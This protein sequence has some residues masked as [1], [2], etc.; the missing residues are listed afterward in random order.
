MKNFLRGLR[1]TWPYRGRLWASIVCAFFAA[2]LWSL[3]LSAVYPVLVLLQ[4]HKDQ[5]TWAQILDGHIK[6]LQKDEADQR[7]NLEWA[8]ARLRAAEQANPGNKKDTEERVLSGKIASIQ[9]KLDGLSWKIYWHQVAKEFVVR[10]LPPERFAALAAFFGIMLGAVALRGV[11]E[12]LQ[13]SLV[14]SVTNRVIC[15]LR[16]RVF[17]NVIHLDVGHFN[18]QGSHGT[19]ANL[20]N[21]TEAF[22]VGVRMLYGRVIGE[23]LKALACVIAACLLAWQ[24]TLLFLVLVPV[25]AYVLA[26]VGRMMK[27]AS[28]RLLERMSD[29]Y[30]IAGEA[31]RAIRVV[32]AFTAEA[33]ERKRFDAAA[34]A[35]AAKAVRVINLDAATSPV[36]ELLGVGAISV[37]LLAGAYLVLEGK[38]DLFGFRLCDYPLDS[39]TLLQIYALLAAIADPVRKLSSVFTKL[40]SGA[41]AADRVFAAL[42]QRPKVLANSLGPVLSRHA[43]SIQFRDVCFS[44]EPGRSTLSNI[45]LDIRFGETVALVGKNGCGKSTLV[46]LL[47]RFY[48]P[49]YGA[50]LVDGVELRHAHLRSLRRQVGLVTQETVLFDDTVFSNIAYGCRRA[51]REQ[52]EEVSRRAYAHDFIEKMSAGYDTRIGDAGAKLSGGQ[53]QR[54]ALARAMLRDP[55]ILILDEF[56]SQCDAESEALIHQALRRFV[57]NRTT[58]IISHR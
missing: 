33:Q 19:M 55:A 40:Q 13:E 15:D 58:F 11:F 54:I 30:R 23:P 44:Y 2:V 43:E 42:D 14:G 50:V 21:D 35:Y 57:K 5:K 24:L 49:D 48:D 28:R 10:C 46:G 51:T 36:I 39:P 17:R 7:T 20:T 37:A 9:S 26:K 31:F 27:R 32:K 12:Y 4:D 29:L 25:S 47:P 3:N 1:A 53:R 8:Q 16:N 41:A 18:D 45:R 52:V 56:T 34:K 6:G 22:G 38:T